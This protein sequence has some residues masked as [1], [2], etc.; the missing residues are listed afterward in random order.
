MP[1]YTA[2]FYKT[3]SNDTGHERR[4]CQRV[5]RVEALTH[6]S[7]LVLAKDRFCTLVRIQDWSTHADNVALSHDRPLSRPDSVAGNAGGESRQRL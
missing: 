5:V 1:T 6:A 2:I 3:V 4:V 7:A